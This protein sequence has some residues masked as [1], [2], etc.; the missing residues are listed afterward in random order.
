M[1]KRVVGIQTAV[2]I[3]IFLLSTCQNSTSSADPGTLDITIQS[4]DSGVVA[5]GT[6]VFG[7]YMYECG[8]DDTYDPANCLAIREITIGTE[9]ENVR[10]K[11]TDGAWNPTAEDWVGDSG[12]GRYDLYILVDLNGT[13]DLE[14][15]IGERTNGF[16]STVYI[17]GDTTIVLDYFADLIER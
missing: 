9:T 17:D 14:E 2:L 1:A 8:T 5:S 3:S 12:W 13:G 6:A 7:A 15:G 16:P 11:V 10:L 4:I